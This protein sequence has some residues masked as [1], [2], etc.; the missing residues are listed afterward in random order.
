[1]IDQIKID[2]V[3]KIKLDVHLA[4][5]TLESKLFF[6]FLSSWEMSLAGESNNSNRVFLDD[7]FGS[8]KSTPANLR[9]PAPE[10]GHILKL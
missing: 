1:M 2:N 5:S 8:L 4:S 6:F 3:G 10:Q 7:N 9:L